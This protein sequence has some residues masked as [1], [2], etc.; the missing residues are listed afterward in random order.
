ML[1]HCLDAAQT[2]QPKTRAVLLCG[3]LS[4][5]TSVEFRNHPLDL[6]GA[7]VTRLLDG[8]ITEAANGSPHPA[9]T[10]ASEVVG[11]VTGLIGKEIGYDYGGDNRAVRLL[12]RAR[13]LLEM[14]LRIDPAHYDAIDSAITTV[15]VLLGE[16]VDGPVDAYVPGLL[17]LIEQARQQ[18]PALMVASFAAVKQC[19]PRIDDRETRLKIARMM[20]DWAA[21]KSAGNRSRGHDL[22]ELVLHWRPL[23]RQ[24]DPPDAAELN[25]HLRRQGWTGEPL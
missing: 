16:L 2:L 22:R 17:R 10:F 15:H 18:N 6:N 20:I 19:L 12:P 21:E 25:R 4:W 9:R 13:Q 14:L 23:A 3:M 7:F 8:L 24:I 5:L 11:S 1:D